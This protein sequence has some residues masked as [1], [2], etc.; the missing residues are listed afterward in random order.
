MQRLLKQREYA[1][2]IVTQLSELNFAKERYSKIVQAREEER[3]ALLN[4][5]LKEK[6]V[7]LLRK[8]T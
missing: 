6:G 2:K 5:K 7:K 1:D 3:Q 4:S 8:R